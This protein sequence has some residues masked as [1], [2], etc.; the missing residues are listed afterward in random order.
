MVGDIVFLE[1]TRFILIVNVCPLSVCLRNFVH[2][3]YDSLVAIC[4]ERAVLLA[5][6]SSCLYFMPH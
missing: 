2:F 6:R 4:W 5:F 1:N 3:I